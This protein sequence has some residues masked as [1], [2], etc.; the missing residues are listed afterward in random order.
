MMDMS[1]NDSNNLFI[2][3]STSPALAEF[4]LPI[5]DIVITLFTTFPL[6]ILMIDYPFYYF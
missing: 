2:Y 6:T 5:N 1:P 4:I 3:F